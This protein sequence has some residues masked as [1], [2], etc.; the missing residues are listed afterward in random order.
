MDYTKIFATWWSGNCYHLEQLNEI[1]S[2]TDVKCFAYILHDKCKQENNELKKPHYHFLIQLQRN[3][4]GSWFKQFAAE[5]MGIVF[6]KPCSF[7]KSAFDYLI[8]NTEACRKEKKFLYDPSE[9]VSTIEDFTGDTKESEHDELCKDLFDLLDRKIT[10][11]DLIR[12]KPKRIHMISNISKAHD[13]LSQER[14]GS[15]DN[16]M[17]PV[18]PQEAQDM[19][20]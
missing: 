14:H 2:S 5:D 4:R 3:Q 7:P 19:P 6:A 13:L 16:S 1:I 20:W 17:R 10:W 15:R 12:K 8:H 9:R 18:T 11:H